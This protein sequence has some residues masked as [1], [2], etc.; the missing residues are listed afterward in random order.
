MLG[1]LEPM[2]GSIL[3]FKIGSDIL[4]VIFGTW[5]VF[6]ALKW[7]KG[8]IAYTAIIWG[9]V[10]GLMSGFYMY[11]FSR[12][13]TIIATCLLIGVLLFPVLTYAVPSVNRF[14]VGYIV[15]MKIS[16][17]VTTY[18]FK[19]GN[20]ELDQM[21]LTPVVIGVLAGLILAV[22]T[23]MSVLPFI[24][25]CSFLGAS[26]VA[27][28]VAEY[29]NMILAGI[30]GD[31]WAWLDPLD[32]LFGIF[33]IELTDGW[34]LLFMAVFMGLGIPYQIKSVRAQGFTLDTPIVVYETS[35]PK[36]HGRIERR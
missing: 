5:M 13:D 32:V 28:T 18:L 6:G 14:V 35:D 11:D 12:S 23:E 16:F 17:M 31:Y 10:L 1:L 15:F 34:T 29:V 8:L 27:P 26:Y 7:R 22:W 4:N 19:N 30:A 21:F 3:A 20:L 25:A 2:A 33:R 9:A 24:I 36:K